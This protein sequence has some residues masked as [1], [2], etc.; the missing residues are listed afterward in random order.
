MKTREE[1]KAEFKQMTPPMG[2]FHIKNTANG[3]VFIGSSSDLKAIWHRQK[4]QLDTGLHVNRDLQK[5]W[6]EQ[7]MSHFVYEI[8]EEIKPSNDPS[9]DVKKEL[10]VLEALYLEAVQPFGDKGYN[11]KKRSF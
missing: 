3:K 8:L 2:V 11:V 6:T 5:D 1:L 9:F 10:Q 4:L 7:G